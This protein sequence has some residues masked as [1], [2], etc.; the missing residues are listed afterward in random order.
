[1][2]MIAPHGG[3]L[4][5]RWVPE[6][7]RAALEEEARTLPRITLSER[8]T[9]DLEM[10][11]IGALSPLEGFMTEDDYRSVLNLRRLALGLPWTIPVTLAVSDGDAKDIRKGGRIAL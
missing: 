6:A 2:A 4:V 9:A 5:D 10:I 11:A 3:R 7:K 1:M 8:E